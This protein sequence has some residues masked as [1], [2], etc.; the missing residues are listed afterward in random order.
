MS[1]DNTLALL[2]DFGAN[3][4]RAAQLEL[5]A[6]HPKKVYRAKWKN[7]RLVSYKT[8]VKRYTSTSTGDLGKSLRYEVKEVLGNLI[9]VF[10]A[11]EY[12]YYVNFGRKK[13]T[14]APVKVIQ[15]WIKNR[16]IKPQDIRRDK[17]GR[18]VSKGFKKIT[19]KTIAGL[20]FMFNR[21]IKTFGIEGNNFFT[22]SLEFE[23]DDI[24]ENLGKKIAKD[25]ANRISKWP[26]Q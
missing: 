23:M 1:N 13:G 10:Y 19:P 21:K 3:V 11:N 2:E 12:W 6:K 24:R 5:K 14:Y 9:V 17:N 18:L 15:E 26:T 8:S 25:L 7:G 22:K 16:G 4:V 20:T